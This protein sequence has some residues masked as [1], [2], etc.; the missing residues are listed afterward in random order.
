[1]PSKSQMAFALQ[2]M[3]VKLQVMDVFL[4]VRIDLIQEP[5]SILLMEDT[6]EAPRLV[7]EGLNIHNFDE[8]DIPWLGLFDFEWTREVV[9]SSEVN[10]QDV[11]GAIIVLD[12]AAGPV[13]TFDLDRFSIFDRAAEWDVRMPSVV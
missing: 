10:V 2:C 7:L 5:A 6:C 1:M 8:K 9:D 11:V 13:E 3:S 4:R 12:L